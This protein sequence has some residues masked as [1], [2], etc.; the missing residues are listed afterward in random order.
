MKKL[1]VFDLDGVLIDSLPNMKLSWDTVR[2]T[3]NIET[4]FESY[5]KHIGKPFPDIMNALGVPLKVQS[6][7]EEASE[8]NI[9]KVKL[10]EGAFDTLTVLK[11][12]YKIAICTSKGEKRT[13]LILEQLPDFDWVCSPTMGLRGTPAPDQLLHT[14]AFCNSEPSETIYI[15]DMQTDYECAK[16]AGVDFIHA[17]YGYG[18]VECEVS[19]KSITNLNSLLD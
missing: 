8:Q 13:N 7:Y 19:L 3:H 17:K 2:L 16:R 6:T 9:D 1:I 18:E 4:P 15:G 12:N 10:Y 5:Q 11:Q 14:M